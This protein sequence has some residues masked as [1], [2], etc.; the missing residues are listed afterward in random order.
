MG[1]SFDRP[2]ASRTS[3]GAI[4]GVHRLSEREPKSGEKWKLEQNCLRPGRATAKMAVWP[5]RRRGSDARRS[6]INLADA[7][8]LGKPDRP[9]CGRRPLRSKIEIEFMSEIMR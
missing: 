1:L 8:E 6:E 2:R 4:S 3:P 5:D 9:G 7:N